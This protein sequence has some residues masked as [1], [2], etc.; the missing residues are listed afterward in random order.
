MQYHYGTCKAR[1]GCEHVTCVNYT[2]SYVAN[3][4]KCNEWQVVLQ[5][6]YKNRTRINQQDSPVSLN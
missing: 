4:K 5:K 1:K 2:E 6:Q 3:D